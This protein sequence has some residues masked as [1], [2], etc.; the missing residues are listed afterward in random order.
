MLPFSHNS[1]S[2]VGHWCWGI[3]PGSQSALQFI[4][5][6]FDGVE[7]SALCR[8][9]KFFHTDLNKP[10]LYG[11]RFVHGGVV[12]LNRKRPS[13]NCFHKVGSAELS[14][15]SLYAGALRFPEPWKTATDHYSSSTKL[16]SWHYTLGQVAV[17]WHPPNPDLFVGL[18][19]GEA[20]FTTPESLFPLLQSPLAASFT[21][22]QLTLGMVILGLYAWSS[23]RT[24]IVLTLL[25]EAVRILVE[26][27]ATWNSQIQSFEG[28][29]VHIH[30]Y[31]W[32]TVH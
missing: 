20:W 10:F 18:P 29:S 6:V 3:R 4:P 21:T 32:C 31:I 25:P 30:L 16:Y 5:K 15:M 28:V 2:E 1:I 13:Q 14:I 27:I 22:L 26:S 11:P 9:V 8:P 24:V 23:L 7:V 17:S 19:D 12:M